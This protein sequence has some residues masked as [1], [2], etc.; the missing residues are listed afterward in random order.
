MH[1][2][3]LHTAA[4]E[5]IVTH[6][7]AGPGS[8]NNQAG[9]YLWWCRVQG[10]APVQLVPPAD[11]REQVLYGISGHGRLVDRAGS[12]AL[13]P[14]LTRSLPVAGGLTLTAAD[15]GPVEFLYLASPRRPPSSEAD[16]ADLGGMEGIRFPACRWGRSIT[17]GGSPVKAAGF[18][19][20]LSILSPR[21][22]QVPWHHHPDR[23]NEVYLLLGGRAEMCI[24][25]QVREI[26]PPAA[27]FVPGDQWHQVTNLHASEPLPLL[28]CYEGS[29]A[30]PHWWQERDGVL[31]VAAEAE[32]PELPA[33]AF[34]QCTVTGHDDWKRLAAA[35]WASRPDAKAK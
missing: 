34:P 22:G 27:V 17:N 20:G 9:F 35:H 1:V 8:P 30:A 31:P 3:D 26:A 29:V 21:G 15:E 28:Y 13:A 18:T 12:A 19:A 11:A 2:L 23:Q 24:G 25:D 10:S 7:V 14:L 6:S 16:T 4:L 32:A 33:G 5:G